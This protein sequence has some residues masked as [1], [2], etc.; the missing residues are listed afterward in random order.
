MYFVLSYMSGRRWRWRLSREVV[1][2]A[3]LG[4]GDSIMSPSVVGR[5]K[6]GSEV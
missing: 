5:E 3:L 1:G 6:S 2:E 4:V